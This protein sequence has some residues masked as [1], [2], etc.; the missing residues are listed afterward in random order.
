MKIV[1]HPR[2]V[3]KTPTTKMHPLEGCTILNSSDDKQLPFDPGDGTEEA[4]SRRRSK[5]WGCKM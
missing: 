1:R 3:Y 5:I 4:L 2:K